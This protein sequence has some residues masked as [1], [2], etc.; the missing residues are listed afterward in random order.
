M[1]FENDPPDGDDSPELFDRISDLDV[2]EATSTPEEDRPLEQIGGK[3]DPEIFSRL[4]LAAS[5][6]LHVGIP[7][8]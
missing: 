4:S 7:V 3:V 5:A 1:C 2:L 8:T 6:V